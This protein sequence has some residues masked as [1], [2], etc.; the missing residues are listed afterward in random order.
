MDTIGLKICNFWMSSKKYT[1]LFFDLDNTLWDFT[2]NSY[3]ALFATLSQLNLLNKIGSYDQFFKIYSEENDRLWELYRNRKRT[4]QELRIQRFEAAFARIGIDPRV[5]GALL[6]ETY[7]TEMLNQN[8]LIDGAQQ[9]L[10]HL[11]G[12]YELAIITNGFTEVQY[13]KLKKSNIT[14]YFRKVFISEEIGAS[15]PGRKIFEH[16]LKSMNAP[17]KSTLM[18]GDNWDT[19]ILGASKF[20]IDQVYFNPQLELHFKTLI[21]GSNSSEI[22]KKNLQ[23]TITPPFLPPKQITSIKTTTAYI[24]HLDQLLIEL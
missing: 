22:D 15:K 9:L 24:S 3:Q 2:S 6:N 7:F 23:K 11:H 13:D 19:D 1:H 14:R 17:K 18:I 12:K 5:D 21:S 10:D 8:K 20:G 16:A 4:K